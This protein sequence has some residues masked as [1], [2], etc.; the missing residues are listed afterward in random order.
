MYNK[1]ELKRKELIKKLTRHIISDVSYEGLPINLRVSNIGK[2]CYAKSHF[3][4]NGI[5][6][7]HTINLS[8]DSLWRNVK[9]GYNDGYY[10][11]RC[12]KLSFVIDDRKIA[13]RFVILH[14]LK[15]V[16]DVSKAGSF[17]TYKL[18]GL[19]NNEKNADDFAIDYLHNKGLLKNKV[20]YNV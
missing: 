17:S 20:L 14:E 1:N 15:H 2:R 9:Y 16:I 18:N 11:G 13:L 7:K 8:L 5:L 10:A 4:Y 6:I 12:N 3:T 19:Y